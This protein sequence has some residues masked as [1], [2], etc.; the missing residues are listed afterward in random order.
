MEKT[1]EEQDEEN[2]SEKDKNAIYSLIKNNIYRSSYRYVNTV[3]ASGDAS[4]HRYQGSVTTMQ[5][6]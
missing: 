1:R 3:Y 4:V 5:S 2:A 6:N